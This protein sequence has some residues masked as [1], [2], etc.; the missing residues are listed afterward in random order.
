[1]WSWVVFGLKVLAPI[2]SYVAGIRGEWET[3]PVKSARTLV[4]RTRA[5]M[6]LAVVVAVGLSEDHFRQAATA[7]AAREETA[8]I[9]MDAAATRE[10]AAAAREETTA[11]REEAAVIREESALAA[12]AARQDAEGARHALHRLEEGL[13]ALIREPDLTGQEALDRIAEELREL[14]ERSPAGFLRRCPAG[15]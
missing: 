6:A 7:A 3:L 13:A 9:R 12:A 14:H 8:A 1:M 11:L 10:D 2:L 15:W 4:R 5:Q